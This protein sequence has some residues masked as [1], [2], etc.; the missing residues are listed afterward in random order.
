M[1]HYDELPVKTRKNHYKLIYADPPWEY[2]KK[3]DRKYGGMTYNTMSIADLEA[4]PVQD[5]CN[6]ESCVLFLWCTWPKLFQAAALLEAWGFKYATCGF[7][8]IKT[9]K[10][11]HETLFS[12]QGY[13]TKPNSEICLIG[14]MGKSPRILDKTVKQIVI[15][16]LRGHSQK[17]DEVRDRLNRMFGKIPKIELFARFVKPGDKSGREES[18]FIS[19]WDSMGDNDFG[20]DSDITT[21][22]KHGKYSRSNSDESDEDEYPAY[23]DD[24]SKGSKHGRSRSRSSSVG[25]SRSRSPS[26]FGAKRG[27]RNSSSRSSN[28]SHSS[29]GRNRGKGRSQSRTISRRNRR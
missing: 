24:E 21:V 8:W 22:S 16:P 11:N 25:R 18:K 19:G 1:T 10:K 29:R 3:V 23:S 9:N 27:R 26:Q 6:K 7:N 5:I 15:S 12:N 20:D 28:R 4:M 13:Y 2:D 14:R 17:P